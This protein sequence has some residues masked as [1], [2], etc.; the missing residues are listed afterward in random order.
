MTG[1]TDT[2]LVYPEPIVRGFLRLGSDGA[3]IRVREQPL[4]MGIMATVACYAVLL[5]KGQQPG[6]FLWKIRLTG[7]D[8]SW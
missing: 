5:I 1:S 4:L 2:D 6:F 3:V 7:I 8:R